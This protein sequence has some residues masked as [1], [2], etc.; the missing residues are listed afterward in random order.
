L[1]QK[2]RRLTDKLKVLLGDDHENSIFLET[3]AADSPAED[4]DE[5]LKK[6]MKGGPKS[7]WS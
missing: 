2:N 5:L 3:E 4:I 7:S 6:L 1:K